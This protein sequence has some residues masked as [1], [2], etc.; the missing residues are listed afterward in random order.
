M[1]RNRLCTLGLS[2]LSLVLIAGTAASADD[3]V[4]A[5]TS[6]SVTSLTFNHGQ[7]FHQTN[8]FV[9]NLRSIALPGSDFYVLWDETSST[10]QMSHY[11]ALSSDGNSINGRVH[12]TSYTVRL[13][14]AN[15]DPM[16]S[17]PALPDGL[18]A[19]ANN[20]VYI[21]QFW[22]TPTQSVRDQIDQFGGE[23]YRFLSDHSFIV[24]LDA[25]AKAQLQNQPYVRWIGD[26][27]P[28]YKLS[29]SLLGIAAGAIDDDMPPMV[30]IEVFARGEEQQ[31]KVASVLRN[32]G[33][34]VSSLNGRG[35][36]FQAA[37]TSNLLTQIASMN[38][39]HYMDPWGPGETDMD[40]TREITGANF[41]ENTLGFSGQGVR[42]EIFDTGII[43]NHVDFQSPQP[44]LMHGTPVA[45]S[46]GNACY[47]VN[48]GTGT[49]NPLAR[50]FMPDNEQGIFA[51]YSQV[52]QFGGA[53][54][55]HDLTAESVD[56]NGPYRAVFQTSSVGSPRNLEYSTITAETDDYLFL[57]GLL[58]T[59]SQSNSGTQMSRPQAWAKNIVS[60][61]GFYPE[62]TLTRADDH[63]SGGASIG[64]AEDGRIK[65]DLAAFYDDSFT[66]Y[67][68]SPTG[69]GT[70]NGTSNATPVTAGMF[71][72]FHQIWHEGVIPNGGGGSTVFDSRPKMTTAKAIM[73]N[74]A[75][76]Y[77][78]LSGGP[79]GDINRNVQGWGMADLTNLYNARTKFNF[80]DE[81]DVIVNGETKVYFFDVA[82]GE[83]QFNVTLCYADPMGTTSSN[84]HRINDLSLR[85]SAPNGDVFWG[86]NGLTASNWSTPGGSSNTK[87]TVENV[88][89][90]NP[91]AGQ[92]VVEVIGDEIVQDAHTETSAVDADFAL[93]ATGAAGAPAALFVS[94]SGSVPSLVAPGTPVDVQ[95]KIDP[96]NDTIVSGT[97]KL[98]Y[99]S[100][101]AGAYTEVA[102]SNI[103]G[104]IW[105]ATLPGFD[106]GDEPEF[107]ASA[108][109]VNTGVKTTPPNAPTSTYAY[110]IGTIATTTFY[111]QDFESGLP[112]GWNATGLWG[113]GTACPAGGSPCDGP[114]YAYYTQPGTC[115]FNTGAA[116]SGSLT[117][118]PID[119]T[120]ATAAELTFCYSLRTENNSSYDQFT[121]HANGQQL[122]QLSD[123]TNWTTATVDLSN[124]AGQMVTL[125]FRFDTVDSIQNDH[126]GPQIDGLVISTSMVECN[127]CYPD[128]DGSGSLNVFDYICFGNAY[129]ANDPYADCDGSGSFNV[130]DYICFGNAYAAGCQ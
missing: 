3:Y 45:D 125:E 76:R 47:G 16:T 94:L 111:T 107:Y 89:V 44:P 65:P 37:L 63:W 66:T 99:R 93:V 118:A 80:I 101:S 46:H 102:L 42:G 48:F 92:W 34:E 9:S 36:R 5:S 116:N 104:N 70:F 55:R 11:Y 112:A 60:V 29:D 121:V 30:S 56:P 75:Y 67:S 19:G 31:R 22:G 21:V 122:T 50:G 17:T 23:I 86:N 96:G 41:I 57:H 2:A 59:Q 91:V 90:Q 83:P 71:G 25:N 62:D 115:T 4:G 79:N 26:F 38:E 27:H 20:D 53:K 69:Y 95:V 74:T 129:A 108:E 113:I 114:N 117:S 33:I 32:A 68:T 49:G 15:F 123:S 39:V 77:N 1:V 105:G 126:E 100:S 73:I 64:P 13:R 78:W 98:Y 97:E 35:F 124:F 72:L 18:Q 40:M 10:G 81:T 85:V 58:S 128:C 8:N 106:C 61:G 24:K 88:F 43:A 7:Q 28:A 6:G 120:G 110:E 103:S 51:Q 12:Q 109:G 52:T 130:F 84:Q 54:P 14:Y 127:G 82:S 87:D 119:L